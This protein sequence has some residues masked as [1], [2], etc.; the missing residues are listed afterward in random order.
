[1]LK[2]ISLPVSLTPAKKSHLIPNI[3]RKFFSSPLNTFISIVGIMIFAILFWNLFLWSVLN[4]VWTSPDGTSE[5]CRNIEG[6]CWAV[7]SERWRL[8]IFGLFPYEEQWRSTIACLSMILIS[9]LTC[10]PFFWRPLRLI[11]LWGTGFVTFLVLM[12][13]GLFGLSVIDSSEWGGLTLTVFIYVTGI[14]F[15]MPMAI[16]FAL[17]RRSKLPVIS[18]V[19]G[20]FID[21]VRS[22]PLITILFTT[23]LI[24]PLALPDWLEGNKLYRVIIGFAL[25]YAAYQAEIIRSGIQAMTVGQEEASQAL[26]LSYWHRTF[27]ITLPQAFRYALPPTVNQFVITFKETSLVVIIGFFEILASG[28]A[29]YGNAEWSFAYVEVYVFI[30]LIY[31]VFVFSLSRYG[32]FLERKLKY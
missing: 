14:L 9:L 5:V 11:A 24:L 4:A 6:A 18:F 25:F 26:G 16:V 29:A 1:M 15:G 21:T 3:K 2:S 23:A 30:A 19:T 31:F 28:N 17:M 20:L 13:G 27:R 12:C 32:A 22:L 7:I 8:I 10:M